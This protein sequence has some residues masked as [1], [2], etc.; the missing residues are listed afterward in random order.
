[1]PDMH[2]PPAGW[3]EGKTHI[4]PV[5]VYYEDTDAG[6]IVYH[7][8][9]LRFCER[10]RNEMLRL[11]GFPHAE[12][13]N[14]L[15]TALAVRHCTMDFRGPAKL[16]QPLEVWS[17]VTTIGAATVDMEQ[18]V[19]RAG[20]PPLTGSDIERLPGDMLVRV[21]LRLAAINQNGR[22]VRLPAALRDVL[23]RVLS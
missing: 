22:P 9:Y 19:R 5:R 2:V 10:A 7:A 12:M 16:D 6:G 8:N 20:L 17:R 1:M 21:S 14:A 23:E 15:G 4:F 13:V 18:E 11:A 3:T